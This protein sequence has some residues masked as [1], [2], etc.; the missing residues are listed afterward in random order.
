MIWV[1]S[2][3]SH[4]SLPNPAITSYDPQEGFNPRYETVCLD[5]LGWDECTNCTIE[6]G[7]VMPSCQAS[8][9]HTTAS[10]PGVTLETLD[11][12]E[13]YWRATNTSDKILGCYNMDAC[14]GG[15]TGAESFCAPGY[16]G[17][18]E[19]GREEAFR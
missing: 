2:S 8:L 10:E 7:N 1:Y 5:C 13:G 3:I 4:A 11:I 6:R 12:D 14:I 17:P 16:T 18:C 19:E 9:E 15:V